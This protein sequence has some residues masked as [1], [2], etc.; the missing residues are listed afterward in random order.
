MRL[1]AEGLKPETGDWSVRLRTWTEVV[2]ACAVSHVRFRT[3]HTS[4]AVVVV[5][6]GAG[7]IVVI[8]PAKRF[9]N[10]V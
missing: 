10:K 3:L 4:N 7:A 1:D 9:P 6:G 8:A 2:Q 5:S